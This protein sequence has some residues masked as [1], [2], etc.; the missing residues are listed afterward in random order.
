MARKSKVKTKSSS[1]RPKVG[2]ASSKK[3]AK[4]KKPLTLALGIGVISTIKV[5]VAR[6]N[7]F[8]NGLDNPNVALTVAPGLSYKRN[9]LQQKIETF[10]GDT[11]I[12]LIVTVGGLIA[13][14]AA[15]SFATKP[16]VSLVGIEPATPGTLCFGGVTLQSYMLN[17]ARV[18]HLVARGLTTPQIALFY[19]P[20]SSMSGTEIANWN[21]ATPPIP[22]GVNTSGD[23]DPAAFTN[24]FN[25]LPAAIKAVVISAD[26]FFQEEMDA[27]VSAANNSGRYICYPLQDFGNASPPPT[28]GNA[29]LYGPNLRSP[30][31]FLGQCAATALTT[32]AASEFIAAPDKIK[33]L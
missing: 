32:G 29:T 12:G 25:S 6:K 4:G 7:A 28:P 21:G 17:Y 31:K 22:G 11:S 1:K 16:F 9:K 13:Y 2:A 27:L 26:P 10:N 15:E 5:P 33:D 19:N 24:D 8:I 23:N 3:N 30:F 20:N 18:A 14:E